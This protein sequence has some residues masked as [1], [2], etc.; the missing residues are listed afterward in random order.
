MNRLDRVNSA[1]GCAGDDR[2]GMSSFNRAPRFCD[3][4]IRGRFTDSDRVAR[5]T[6]IVVDRNV[7]GRHIGK[8]LQQP[9][10][11]YF[12]QAIVRPAFEF[13]FLGIIQ[14]TANAFLKFRR[15][16]HDV[17]RAKDDAGTLLVDRLGRKIGVLKRHLRGSD[18]HL[19][20]TAHYLQTLADL[21]LLRRFEFAEVADMT[22]E[23]DRLTA[24]VNGQGFGGDKR[25][26]A[27]TAFSTADGIPKRRPV[28]AEGTDQ[29]HS[30]DHN[31]TRCRHNV[32][33]YVIGVRRGTRSSWGF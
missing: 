22:R 18:A 2:V 26:W 11:C 9:K 8:I 17:V 29:T 32:K 1:S 33:N 28:V 13:E 30:G 6:Q 21:F 3:R 24:G 31:S 19:Y 12:R 15:H 7:A 25:Q 5:T 27:N 4:Q 23:V 14:A 10:R 16:R 20:L